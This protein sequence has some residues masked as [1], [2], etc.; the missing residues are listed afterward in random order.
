MKEDH[1]V[2]ELLYHNEDHIAPKLPNR[3]EV[4]QTPTTELSAVVMVTT[5][6]N[7]IRR[8]NLKC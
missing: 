6:N 4:N 7:V 1:L 8:Q 5:M 3:Y 2:S